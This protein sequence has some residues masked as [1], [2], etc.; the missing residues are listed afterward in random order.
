VK[1]SVPGSAWPAGWRA[2]AVTVVA[3]VVV[4]VEVVDVVPVVLLV[5]GAGAGV[6]LG[7]GADDVGEGL[8]AGVV[9]G[10]VVPVEDGVDEPEEGGEDP[11]SGS[12]YC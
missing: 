9:A 2:A 12:M 1:G 3:D 11:A 5:D 7:V 6:E 8:D 10:A 4:G